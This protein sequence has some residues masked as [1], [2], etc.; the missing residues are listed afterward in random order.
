MPQGAKCNEG[1]PGPGWSYLSPPLPSF[2]GLY[3]FRGLVL[4]EGVH[5]AIPRRR[6]FP[7]VSIAQ[8]LIDGSHQAAV[9]IAVLT[10]RHLHDCMR[11]RGMPSAKPGITA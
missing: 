1:S 7:A 10:G 2:G 9:L 4:E 8:A 11:H 3:L 5:L 6:L